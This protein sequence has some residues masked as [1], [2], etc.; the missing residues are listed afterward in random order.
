MEIKIPVNEWMKENL[1]RIAKK[2]NVPIETVAWTCVLYVI[3]EKL[4]DRVNKKRT[5]EAEII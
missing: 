4:E 1:E 5:F 2:W 3:T